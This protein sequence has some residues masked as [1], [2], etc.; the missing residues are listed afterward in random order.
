MTQM[1]ALLPM[2]CIKCQTPIPAEPDEVAWLCSNCGQ[3]LLLDEKQASGLATLDIYFATGIQSG[4]R[5]RP[6]WVA[7]GLV[8]VQRETYSGNEGRQAQEFWK[9]PR[10]FFIPA[11]AC[12]LDELISLGM[13]LLKQPISM[14]PAP[15]A[16]FLPVTLSPQDVRP[17]AEFIIMGIEAER[18]DMMKSAAIQLNLAKPVLWILP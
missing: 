3:A 18:R 12:A 7:Q 13:Q 6:F 4:Q 2:Q 1:P 16:A 5:G 17:M 11:Y 10:T 14:M 9:K 8:S 15:A